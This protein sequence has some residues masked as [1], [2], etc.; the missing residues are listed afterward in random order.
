MTPKLTGSHLQT[1]DDRLRL[2]VPSKLIPTLREL[3]GVSEDDPLDV[4][5]TITMNGHL[6]VYPRRVFTEMFEK[7]EQAPPE[8]LDAADLRLAYL[9]Y[10]DEQSLDKQ[11]RFRVPQMHAEAFGL[12]GEVVVMGSERF[13][14][15]VSKAKWNEILK[16]RQPKLRHQAAQMHQFQRELRSA[17]G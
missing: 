9:N 16:D 1:L 10:M 4:V 17:Q 2:A 7:L 13:L 15:V 14:E 5:V 8:D 3:A 12:S 11:N 6:G